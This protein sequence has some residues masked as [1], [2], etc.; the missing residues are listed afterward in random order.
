[1]PIDFSSGFLSEHILQM[2]DSRLGIGLG[3]LRDGGDLLVVHSTVADA[4]ADFTILNNG[5]NS[6]TVRLVS[7]PAEQVTLNAAAAFTITAGDFLFY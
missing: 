3:R 4:F 7:N 2:L 1:M 6:V 5:T